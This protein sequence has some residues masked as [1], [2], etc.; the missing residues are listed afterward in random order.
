[1]IDEQLVVCRGLIDVS[2][3]S[4]RNSFIDIRLLHYDY[5]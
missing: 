4:L 5:T 3:H 1:M 2:T